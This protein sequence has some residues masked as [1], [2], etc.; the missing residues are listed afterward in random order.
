[1]GTR[2]IPNKTREQ[3]TTIAF[4]KE[5]PAYL[6]TIAPTIPATFSRNADNCFRLECLLMDTIARYR[7]MQNRII[8]GYAKGILKDSHSIAKKKVI[9][10]IALPPL[11]YD[12]A[13]QQI[14]AFR[15]MG[16]FNMVADRYK[17]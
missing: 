16:V 5:L 3:C 10:L 17:L 2:R 1:M 13:G 11:V 4:S 9:S 6:K 8:K 12:I 15:E 7:L 14:V